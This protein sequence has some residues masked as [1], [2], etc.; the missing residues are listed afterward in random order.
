MADYGGWQ[1]KVLRVD[2][3]TGKISSEDTVA[4]YKDFLGGEG[5]AWKVMWDEVPPGTKAFD[6]EN[7]IIFGVG[8]ATGTGWPTAGRLS[9]T[10]L[11]P[12]SP[13][14]STGSELPATGH[15]GGNF[16]A[17][18]KYA[19]WDSIIIQ[20][21]SADPVWLYINDSQVELRDA[22]HI[23][24]NGIFRA[25]AAISAEVGPE[26]MVTAIGQAGENLV[27]QSNM[28][29]A[30]SHGV[31]GLGGVM[32][33]KNLKAVGVK[34]TKSIKIAADKGDWKALCERWMYLCGANSG[35]VVPST[36]QPWS[37]YYGGGRWWARKGLFWGAAYPAVETGICPPGDVNR[38][39]LRTMKGS[40]DFSRR[41]PSGRI[42]GELI[43]TR[44]GGCTSCP[45]R[46]HVLYDNPRLSQYGYGRYHSNTCSGNQGTQH[47]PKQSSDTWLETDAKQLGS[48]MADD[49]GT[50]QNYGQLGKDVQYLYS[51]HVW[52]EHLTADEWDSIPW[53]LYDAGDPK[54]NLFYYKAHA[55]REGEFGEDLGLGTWRLFK[56]YGLDFHAVDYE[57]KKTNWK[58]GHKYHHSGAQEGA[59]INMLMNRDP[60]NHVHNSYWGNGLPFEISV[61]IM[62]EI[63]GLPGSMRERNNNVPVTRG[64]ARYALLSH[65]MCM[66][67]NS[68]TQCDYNGMSG[69]WVTPWK[70]RNYRGEPDIEAR[71]YSALTGDT[72]DREGYEEIGL[73]MANLF[74][75]L[76]T[77][78][79]DTANMRDDH[80]Q[81]PDYVFEDYGQDRAPF[82]PGHDRLDRDDIEDARDFLYDEFGWSSSGLATRATLEG[83]GLGDVADIMATQNLLG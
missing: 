6:P 30:R 45:L 48:A 15:G 65:I 7:R 37:D 79:M 67:H 34:G 22:R 69:A 83:L 59:L 73:R 71:L 42:I 29:A 55:Y 23:W 5:M 80:D 40:S 25:N 61:A 27:R 10:S 20:G 44:M 47:F 70:D 33:S 76:T 14:Q 38:M 26:V 50:W 57:K 77:R 17:E 8:P 49:Y 32:G 62:D 11:W 51:H 56:K 1:G 68:V 54:F 16:A 18:L 9:V 60:Q 63:T 78:Y 74:R 12:I 64:Q 39:G 24:G 19:G 66:I 72:V 41:D 28:M 35:S 4:K 21:K 46:C 2:L 36:P 53:D 13:E 58:L 31:G 3:S 43:T 75:A 81:C 82:T 52:E